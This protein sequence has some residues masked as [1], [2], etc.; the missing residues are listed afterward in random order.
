MFG[1]LRDSLLKFRHRIHLAHLEANAD[2]GGADIFFAVVRIRRGHNGAVGEQVKAGVEAV[3]E[4][5]EQ[6]DAILAG[7]ALLDVVVGADLGDEA[8]LEGGLLGS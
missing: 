3:F 5:L 6:A 1:L 4:G 8:F 7:L 2:D